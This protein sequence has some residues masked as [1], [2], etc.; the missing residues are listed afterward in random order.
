VRSLRSTL[1]VVAIAV[2]GVA[3]VQPGAAQA[4][5]STTATTLTGTVDVVV[6]DSPRGE[7]G[8]VNGR[9][10]QIGE[11]SPS[12][13]T[14]TMVSAGGRTLAVPPAL[15]VGLRSG[16]RVEVTV[17]SAPPVTRRALSTASSAG[18]FDRQV[19][20]VRPARQLIMAQSGQHPAAG[21]HTLTVLPVYW[22]TADG[23]TLASL[24]ALANRTAGYW[25]AQSGG[26]IAITAVVKGWRKIADP[27]TC[28][29]AALFD[30]ALAAHARANPTAP[31]DH[32]LVYFPNRPD[33]GGWAGLGSVSG[34]R[35]WVNGYALPDVA[36]HEFGHNL[37]LG[38]ANKATCTSGS[39]RVALSSSCTVEPY[40][41]SSDVMGYATWSASGSLNTALADQLG[42]ART[43]TAGADSPATVDLAPLTDVSAVRAVKVDVGTGW[44]YVDY[45]PAVAPDLRRPEWAGVQ[46]HYLP[47]GS[48]PESQLLDLQ[49]WQ[50]SAF[51]STSMPAHSVWRVPGSPVAISV[52]QVGSSARVRV[53]S[54]AADTHAPTAPVVSASRTGT[55]TV[56]AS[57]TASTDTGSGLAGYRVWVDGALLRHEAPSATAATLTVPATAASLRVEAVDAAGN[58]TSSGAVALS[59]GLE[60]RSGAGG[61]DTTPPSA[62]VVTAPANGSASSRTTLAWTW[63]EATDAESAVTAYRLYAN[64]A[65][66]GTVLPASVRSVQVQVPAGRTTRLGVAAVN[67]AGLV[68]P[69]AETSVTVDTLAPAAPRALRLTPGT[70]VLTWTAPSDQGSPLR[71]EVSLDGAAPSLTSLTTS[72]ITAANGRRVW[73]VRAVDAA[74]NASTAVSVT[75]LVDVSPPSRPVLL[76]VT[77]LGASTGASPRRT[78]T[79]AWQPSTDS[80]SWIAG[81]RVQI[82]GQ[83]TVRALGPSTTRVALTLPEGKSTVLISA[84]NGGGTPSAAASARVL[85]TPLRPA[86]Q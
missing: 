24:T 33:C 43:V 50:A 70:G 30:R 74:G 14:T 31:T 1:A 11:Q 52:G 78:V 69:Q 75:T 77:P 54:T 42:L 25:A 48:Y 21:R 72:P 36:A 32:V 79:V 22:T 84:V 26:R 5:T 10:V 39:Q 51:Q 81:Y 45:R 37:G 58:A 40:Q 61:V 68:G 17:R 64:G 49:P 7:Q 23:E 73:S 59:R 38:H 18:P 6:V 41:D 76:A 28:D 86:P 44:V 4:T 56:S 19:I 62:P 2:T 27:G 46:V 65:A 9:L 20:A 82:Q 13:V 83:S 35:I 12:L 16:Q 85:V 34:S 47:N 71:Y 67:A 29:A 66:L 80:D 3:L 60:A 8:A 53:F 15:A 57:W 55:S 63:S